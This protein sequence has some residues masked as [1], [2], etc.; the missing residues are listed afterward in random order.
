MKIEMHEIEA[1]EP[2]ILN[3]D[4]E[5]GPS[6][7]WGPSGY[8]YSQVFCIAW[9]WVGEPESSVQSVLLDWRQ[10]DATIRRLLDDVFGCIDCADGF[11]GHNFSHD[12]GLL[13]GTAKDCG[14]VLPDVDKPV[15]DTM[16]S[17]PSSTGA[18]RSLEALCAQFGVG[19]KPHI[20]TYTW[21][22]AWVRWDPEALAIVRQRCEADVILT[23]RLYRKEQELGWL[24]KGVEHA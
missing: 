14:A 18:M 4:V 7:G 5:N 13:V 19:E 8:T 10:D 17:V 23:E 11:L 3:L 9:K 12:T 22:K 6:W 16:R 1:V 2:S 21:K 24:P 20:D 15:I